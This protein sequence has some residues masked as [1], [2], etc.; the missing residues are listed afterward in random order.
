MLAYLGV[1]KWKCET[2]SVNEYA[3][4]ISVFMKLPIEFIYNTSAIILCNSLIY[5]FLR[6]LTIQF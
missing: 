1:R 3:R 5:T 2:K 6:Q 4:D